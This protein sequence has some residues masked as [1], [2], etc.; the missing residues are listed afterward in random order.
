M[1]QESDNFVKK[2][3]SQIRWWKYAAWT[4]P[5]AALAG[6]FFINIFGWGDVYSDAL[7]LGSVIFFSVSVFWWWWAIFKISFIVNLIAGTG[8]KFD[9][10]IKLISNIK[11]DL[12]K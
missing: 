1:D 9:R 4:L 2:T 3:Q 10:V 5:F 11:Q 8:E 6:L 12:K 7:V